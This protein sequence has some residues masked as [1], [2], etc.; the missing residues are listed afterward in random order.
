M[1]VLAVCIDICFWC[2]EHGEQSADRDFWLECGLPPSCAPRGVEVFRLWEGLS[3]PVY[4]RYLTCMSSV[5]LCK[6]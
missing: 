5:N 2:K 6:C 4:L 1:V 3:L